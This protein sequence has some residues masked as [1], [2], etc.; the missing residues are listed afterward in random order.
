MGSQQAIGGILVVYFF[1][2][3]AACQLK[4]ISFLCPI[5]KKCKQ[6]ITRICRQGGLGSCI[7]LVKFSGLPVSFILY[8]LVAS[9][10]GIWELLWYF[11]IVINCIT[12][13][14]AYYLIIKNKF[15]SLWGAVKGMGIWELITNIIGLLASCM[16]KGWDFSG[17]YL[18]KL[19]TNISK[20][21][22]QLSAGV[23]K[24]NRT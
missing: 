6:L 1:K 22:Y 23:L 14:K 12:A 19:R 10:M 7:F 13:K 21:S 4:Q 8:L 15:L 3:Q 18:G 20:P 17:P 2:Q 24:K 16:F 11:N 5:F 9:P